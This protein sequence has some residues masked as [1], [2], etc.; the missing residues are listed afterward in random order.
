[1]FDNRYDNDPIARM[2]PRRGPV[3]RAEV[4]L[5][6]GL[7]V[8][9]S[10]TEFC[11]AVVDAR[12]GVLKLEDF[13]GAVRGFP[14]SDAFLVDGKPVKFV[15]PK[16][17]QARRR[18]ASGSF[19]AP[20]ERARVAMPSRIFVEGK[21]DA[22]LVE[23][24][25]G[26][27]LRIEG[28]VVELLD[29]ADHLEQ[30]LAEFKPGPGRRAG[31]LLDHLVTGSKETRIAEAIARGPHGEHVRIVGHPYIDIWEAVKP[32]RLGLTVWPKIPRGIDWK[33]GICRAL[34][35]PSEDLADT[36]EAWQRIRGRVRNFRDLEPQ[37]V[38]RVEELIDFVSVGH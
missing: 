15:P 11:G 12:D 16:K 36:A 5:T 3:E 18:T 21:H 37:L 6:K 34:G 8:E 29:G 32:E 14:L 1:M 27:D 4:E 9:H 19:A 20:L 33:T 35:W 24:V 10:L 2:K 13:D 17:S 26:D 23:Q 30:V 31:V 25:W 28:I 38:G 7:V 22:E